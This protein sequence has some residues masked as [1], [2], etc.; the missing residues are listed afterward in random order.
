MILYKLLKNITFK[1]NLV[2]LYTQSNESFV[3][4]PTYTISTTKFFFHL[5]NIFHNESLRRKP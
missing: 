4:I 1:N 3:L 5:L 2:P